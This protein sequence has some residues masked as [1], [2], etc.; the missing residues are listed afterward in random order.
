MTLAG[1]LEA[2]RQDF[3]SATRDVSAEQAFAKPDRESWSVVECIE[4]VIAVENRYLNW[5]SDGFAIAP[6]RNGDREIRLFAIARSRLT[7]L[8]APEIVRPIGRFQALS[9]AVAK[10]NAVRDRSVE[11]VEELGESIYS[12]GA[13]HPYFGTLNGAELI[14]LMDGH[15]RRHADQIRELREALLG[16]VEEGR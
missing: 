10:F 3:L 5:I 12:I 13:T 16:A 2:G 15:A 9:D 1:V 14:Q 8:E 7:K 6:Q 4:H 11:V